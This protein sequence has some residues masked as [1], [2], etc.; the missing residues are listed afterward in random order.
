MA[1]CFR[2]GVTDEKE[3][4]FD[5]ITNEGVVKICERCSCLENIPIIRKPSNFQLKEAERNQ[6]VLERLSK[7]T[8]VNREPRKVE[9][10]N[11]DE[12][13]Y[14]KKEEELRKVV[15]ANYKRKAN[16][17]KRRE[18]LE[19]NFHWIIMRAR[20]SR[21]ITQGQLAK[22]IAEPESKVQLAESGV[23][24]QEDDAFISK[25]EKYLNI[26]IFKSPAYSGDAEKKQ[27]ARILELDKSKLDKITIS[28]LREMKK[29]R[30]EEEAKIREQ[31]IGE[32][33][34]IEED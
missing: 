21:K 34:D 13:K 24:A 29:K 26:K 25:L 11:F 14:S 16:E 3:Y 19:D 1:E 23:I 6:T 15:E 32:E 5:A 2:C 17:A 33:I 8:G 20:R 4:L 7:I 27:P 9:P 22:D 12:K 28:D 18:D 10:I 30:D 31:E